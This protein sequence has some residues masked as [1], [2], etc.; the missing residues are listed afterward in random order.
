MAKKKS[1][2]IEIEKKQIIV[3]IFLQ[4]TRKVEVYKSNQV[5]DESQHQ[6]Y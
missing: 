1:Y 5:D 4:N 2:K 6:G 3:K